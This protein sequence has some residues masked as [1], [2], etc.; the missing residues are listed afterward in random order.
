MKINQ[1]QVIEIA[2]EIAQHFRGRGSPDYRDM[3]H[4]LDGLKKDVI[5]GKSY[6]TIKDELNDWFNGG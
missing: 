6:E 4:A 5:D 3:V 2:T 1:I